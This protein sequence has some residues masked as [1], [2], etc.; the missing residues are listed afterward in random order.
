MDKAGFWKL[1]EEAR[2]DTGLS[3]DIAPF[4]VG[5]LAEMDVGDIIRWA[6]IYDVYQRLSYKMKLWA[7]AY[8]IN[9]GCSD[10]GFEYFRGWLI[11]Q[12]REVFLNAL[13]NPDSLAEVDVR[14]DEA[15]YEPMLY[16]G[17]EAY[18]I[19]M[20]IGRPDY[21]AFQE[22]AK[23]HALDESELQYIIADIHFAEDIDAEWAEDGLES[24][25]PKLCEKF[26]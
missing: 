2:A 26:S 8:V 16:V 17:G 22:A 4:L 23:D 10:D 1:I 11:A 25:V 21:D 15:E 12:G 13:A 9:G 24:V 18:F 5:R 19:K 6:R 7:A 20:N 14:M 3:L